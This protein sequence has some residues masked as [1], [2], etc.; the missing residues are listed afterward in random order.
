MGVK[1]LPIRPR[2]DGKATKLRDV[3]ELALGIIARQGEGR[4]SMAMTGRVKDESDN[5]HF[6]RF[7]SIYLQF[8][9][10]LDLAR[11]VATNPN[12]TVPL[13]PILNQPSDPE[14][15]L[16]EHKNRAGRIINPITQLWAHL[17]NVRYRILLAEL[18]H[19]LLLRSNSADQKAVRDRLVKW[20]FQEM[21]GRDSSIMA[22][23][24]KELAVRDQY[25]FPGFTA[26][27]PFEVPY[28]FDLPD[29]G[30]DRWRFHR[31]LYEGSKDVVRRL[32]AALQ[33]VGQPV[34]DLLAHLTTFENE[35]DG[36]GDKPPVGRIA[37]I[38]RYKDSEF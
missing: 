21:N 31:D 10:G 37:F 7:L 35:D 38:N 23:A 14:V 25:N 6:M 19:Y 3:A 34:P 12:T 22:L 5:S 29:R 8:P 13:C 16:Q 26:G 20:I 33:R 15:A 24:Q 4:T 30:P 32:E 9:D 28:T 1:V 27:A 17:F 2:P 18:H 36:Y 11:P